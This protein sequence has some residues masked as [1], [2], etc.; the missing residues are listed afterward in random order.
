MDRPS[1]LAIAATLLRDPSS[2]VDRADDPADLAHLA[3]RTL[4]IGVI[5]AALFGITVG[6]Y[7]G[8][9][10]VAYA[11]VKMPLLFGLPLI[12]SL[13]AVR[14]LAHLA[15]VDVAW[16][17]L[18]LAGAIGAART[19]VLAAALGPL[20]WLYYSITPDYHL[21]VLVLAGT[22]VV[23]GIPGLSVVGR[24]LPAGAERRWAVGLASVAVLGLVTAQTG[25][26]LRP[27]VVRPE[28]PVAFLRPVES[29][30]A[31]SLGETSLT[32]TGLNTL[33]SRDLDTSYPE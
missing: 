1:T 31:A 32:A 12:A 6:S 27:F 28:A 2:L 22:L 19:A 10:Q 9:V 21:S 29:D 3:P 20:V 16:P 26:L 4:A 33:R 18:A 24:V 30:I 7:H 25:W 14:S 8:G 11:A 17:R 5:G 15:A 23:A 13:P